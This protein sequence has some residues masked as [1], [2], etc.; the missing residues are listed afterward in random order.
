L[1]LPTLWLIP[2]NLVATPDGQKSRAGGA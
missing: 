2:K 1:I